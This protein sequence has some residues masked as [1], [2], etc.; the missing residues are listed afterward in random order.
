MHRTLFSPAMIE[1]FRTCR[2]AYNLAF[3]GGSLES[4]ERLSVICKQFIL[5]ALAQVHKGKVT[6]IPQ[7]QKYLGQNWPDDKVS[8]ASANKD[9]ATRAFLFVYKTLL[10]YVVKPSIPEGARVVGA[11]LKVRARIP[12]VRV[13]VEDTLDLVLWYPDKLKIEFVDFQIQAPKAIDPA[14]PSADLLVKKFLAER[15]QTRWPFEKLSIACQRVGM[16]DFAPIKCHL[17]ETTYRLHWLELVNS[18]EQMKEFEM[19]DPKNYGAHP[20]GTCSH[21]EIL[22]ARLANSSKIDQSQICLSA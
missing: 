2:Y 16:E 12:H 11:A 9:T 22:E 1:T 6:N 19:S 3:L 15:L 13:Y 17:K 5:R 8:A 20:A 14:W 10:H 4:P 21:C 18:L 7:M